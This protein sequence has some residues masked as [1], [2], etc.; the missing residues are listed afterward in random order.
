MTQPAHNLSPVSS[1]EAPLT[2]SGVADDQLS[3]LDRLAAEL[4]GCSA[5]ESAI[6]RLRRAM[7]CEALS[8]TAGNYTKAA[9]LLGVQRQ[10]VQNMVAR[11]GLRQWARTV[12]G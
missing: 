8:R 4:V 1:V 12:R 3:A 11:Y 2:A 9:L 5:V 6:N 7:L 10:A